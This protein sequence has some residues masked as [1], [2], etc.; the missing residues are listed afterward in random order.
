MDAA[1]RPHG[2]G[3]SL[4]ILDTVRFSLALKSGLPVAPYRAASNDPMGQP[5]GRHGC[6]GRVAHPAHSTGR[7][8]TQLVMMPHCGTADECCCSGTFWGFPEISSLCE[9]PNLEAACEKC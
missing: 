1:G 8:F 9:H 3:N 2:L 4:I 6:C 7:C 5:S